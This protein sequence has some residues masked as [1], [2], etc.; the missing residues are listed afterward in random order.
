M[1][2]I[3]Q[4]HPVVDRMVELERRDFGVPRTRKR[5][6]GVVDQTRYRRMRFRSGWALGSGLN[7]QVHRVI[8]DSELCCWR[9]GR[10]S[11]ARPSGPLGVGIV[12]SRLPDRTPSGS[13][14][15]LRRQRRGEVSRPIGGGRNGKKRLLI[16]AVSR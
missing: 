3:G 6:Q 9:T 14:P 15:K 11:A 12:I 4:L 10:G 5:E 8:R 1:P 7:G 13:V 16:I 2:V